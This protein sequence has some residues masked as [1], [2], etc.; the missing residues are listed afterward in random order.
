[1]SQT[2]NYNKKF[3]YSNLNDVNIII[4]IYLQNIFAATEDIITKPTDSSFS[5]IAAQLE[6]QN[7]SSSVNYEINCKKPAKL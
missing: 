7:P 4:Y 2:Y 5:S 6:R 1:M 3:T